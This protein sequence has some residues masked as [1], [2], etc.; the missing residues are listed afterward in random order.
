MIISLPVS[1]Y[2]KFRSAVIVLLR[3]FLHYLLLYWVSLLGAER[4]QVL[5]IMFSLVIVFA[6]F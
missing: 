1:L 6:M 3:V 2:V 4:V 5:A